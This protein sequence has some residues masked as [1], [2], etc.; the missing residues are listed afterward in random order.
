M[1]SGPGGPADRGTFTL[2]QSRS[3]VEESVHHLLKGGGVESYRAPVAV[4]GC[5]C[6]SRAGR[7]EDLD[8]FL[9]T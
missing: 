2:D 9:E 8:V 6:R 5:C 1:L 3:Y 7:N 4:G